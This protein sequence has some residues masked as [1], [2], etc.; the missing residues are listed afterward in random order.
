MEPQVLSL[1]SGRLS[2]AHS[3][4]DCWMIIFQVSAKK[5]TWL[6]FTLEAWVLDCGITLLMFWQYAEDDKM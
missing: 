5:S 3:S 1:A 6:L 2:E 4:N